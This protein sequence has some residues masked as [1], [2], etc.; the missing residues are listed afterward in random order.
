[1]HENNE[2][3]PA[4]FVSCWRLLMWVFLFG[5]AQNLIPSVSPSCFALSARWIALSLCLPMLRTCKRTSAVLLTR[6]IIV[7]MLA[8]LRALIITP[9][10]SRVF[11]MVIV[12]TSA[13]QLHLHF[14]IVFSKHIYDVFWGARIQTTNALSSSYSH[15]G[16]CT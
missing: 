1:M 14:L 13:L 16:W 6:S 2:I 10:K 12:S 15:H 7:M 9:F 4:C 11:L 8:F 5:K 3:T